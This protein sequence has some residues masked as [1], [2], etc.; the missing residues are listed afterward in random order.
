MDGS[1]ENIAYIIFLN[2]YVVIVVKPRSKDPRNKLLFLNVPEAVGLA[3]SV[4]ISSK[5]VEL[6]FLVIFFYFITTGDLKGNMP[7]GQVGVGT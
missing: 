1:V 4:I 5:K 7:S 6:A 2:K 3:R